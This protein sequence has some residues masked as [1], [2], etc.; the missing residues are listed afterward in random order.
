MEVK[1]MVAD[2]NG[3]KLLKEKI[4]KLIEQLDYA[5]RQLGVIRMEMLALIDIVPQ[6]CSMIAIYEKN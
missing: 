5:E 1:D 2:V 3:L 4:Q 6:F